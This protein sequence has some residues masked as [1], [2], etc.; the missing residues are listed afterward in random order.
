MNAGPEI[1][2]RRT[3]GVRM[4]HVAGFSALAAAGWIG[5]SALLVAHRMPLGPAVDGERR[6]IAGTAGRLSY[7][8]GGE[9]AP[10]LL[11]HSI[12]AAG[13]AY[14][15]RP[16]FQHF[17]ATRRVY[18]I[19]L[20]GFGFSDRSDRHY[21]IPMY[22]AA[23]HD[24]LDEI[25]AETGGVPVDVLALSLASEFVARAA[26]QRPERFRTL[27]LVTPT[28]FSKTYAGVEGPAG[29][30]REIPGMHAIFSFPLWGRAVY[31]LLVSRKSIRYFLERTF[32][33]KNI[34][35]A[36]LDYDYVTTH[37]PGAQ[38]AP[39]AFVSGRLFSRDIRA[40]YERLTLPVWVPHA[41]RGDFKDFSL[42]GWAEAKGN[43]RF[44]PYDAGA[45]PHFEHT[46]KFLIDYEAFLA[47]QRSVERRAL[48]TVPVLPPQD[49]TAPNIG[50]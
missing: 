25:A 11:V 16:I 36:M 1:E 15:I 35:E 32:G 31:D 47:E 27:A 4:R 18:A 30:T 8:V 34:D 17:K 9:G 37:Q 12:N 14:E 29:G 45:L 5:Y 42:R 2:P 50:G 44:Q 49:V 26:T 6:E 21:D 24:I 3:A 48:G 13:S 33:S 10:L 43:W 38:H 28:G 41:T 23:I 19:D 40:V 46:A 22:V 39:Y 7:Y 20:P